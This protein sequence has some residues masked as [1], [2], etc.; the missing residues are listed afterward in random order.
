MNQ[1]SF[2]QIRRCGL[3]LLVLAMT[4]ILYAAPSGAAPTTKT[5]DKVVPLPS[6]GA[7]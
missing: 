1:N 6:G 7:L 2:E 3:M 5:F 4:A